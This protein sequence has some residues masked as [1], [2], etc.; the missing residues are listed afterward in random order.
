MQITTDHTITYAYGMDYKDAF[1]IDIPADAIQTRVR[2]RANEFATIFIKRPSGISQHYLTIV[3][4][5]LS[6]AH[7]VGVNHRC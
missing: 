2:F 4:N 3:G 1:I 5:Q 7:C 6:V